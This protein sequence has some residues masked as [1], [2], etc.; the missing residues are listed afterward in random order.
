MTMSHSRHF[1]LRSDRT[2]LF[3][4]KFWFPFLS[5]CGILGV[6]SDNWRAVWIVSPLIV[7]AVF[8][9]SL[10][11]VQ[12][13]PEFLRYRRLLKWRTITYEEILSCGLVRHTFFG[14]VK[15]KRFRFPWGKLY[16]V[17]DGSLYEDP[18]ARSK[19]E[20]LR[21][22]E[23]KANRSGESQSR[24][25]GEPKR[26]HRIR[27]CLV[28]GAVGILASLMSTLLL[29]AE[30][31]QFHPTAPDWPRWLV[32]YD[33]VKTIALGWPWNLLLFAVLVFAAVKSKRKT[34]WI[35]AFVGGLLAPTLFLG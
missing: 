18:L 17:L 10:A 21:Y 19:S 31:T 22:A 5:L 26:Y 6:F 32:T 30:I 27:R 35:L 14:F 20:L 13:Q 11:E 9:L 28:A 24:V 23:G 7:L 8:L 4:F 2:K 3:L 16:F 25:S 29:P 34:D 33:H 15:L 1:D 12:A